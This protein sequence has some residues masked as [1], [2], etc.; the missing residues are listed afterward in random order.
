MYTPGLG[1]LVLWVN[2][3]ILLCGVRIRSSR[4][5]GEMSPVSGIR[6]SP[7][8]VPVSGVRWRVA[9]LPVRLRVPVV[10]LS[11]F[12]SVM[13]WV[14]QV[15]T[16]VVHVDPLSHKIRVRN[17]KKKSCSS[18]FLLQSQQQ[19]CLGSSSSF[20]PH[21]VKVHQR[22]PHHFTGESQHELITSQHDNK[23]VKFTHASVATGQEAVL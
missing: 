13:A 12:G 20:T 17:G 14:G 8:P 16:S 6:V 7:V 1:P 9:L 19:L 15:V 21:A 2:V 11:V 23:R 10:V 3:R 4:R 5:A 18:C 22:L